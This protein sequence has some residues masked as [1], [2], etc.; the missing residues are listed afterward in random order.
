MSTL[1]NYTESDMEV[2]E[3]LQDYNV[4]LIEDFADVAS[5]DVL[6]CVRPAIAVPGAPNLWRP[7]SKNIKIDL[8]EPARLPN[9]T[10][11]VVEGWPLSP[12]IR[13][14]RLQKPSYNLRNVDIVIDNQKL[15]NLFSFIH[16][17]SSP[18]GLGHIFINALV[19]MEGNTAIWSRI[20]KTAPTKHATATAKPK[21]LNLGLQYERHATVSLMSSTLPKS[22]IHSRIISY[23]LAGLKLLLLY[24]ADACYCEHGPYLDYSDTSGDSTDTYPSVQYPELRIV[25]TGR[26]VSANDI[27]EI[28]THS[29]G[30]NV[31]YETN[32]AQLF[33]T[34]TRK[35]VDAHHDK[36]GVFAPAFLKD[37]SHKVQEWGDMHR[38]YILR[39]VGFLRHVSVL[40]KAN[41]GTLNVRASGGVLCICKPSNDDAKKAV[42][43]PDLEGLWAGGEGGE[44]ASPK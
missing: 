26:R 35:L 30:Q 19:Q 13:A 23:N 38:L 29:C 25:K 36:H 6:D 40:A 24:Q 22:V 41:G 42:L 7:A 21:Q 9:Q 28:K 17:R 44:S 14:V 2:F 8:S 27:I 10:W 15:R 37:I 20:P 5:Y 1:A 11:Q 16:P 34:Q 33:F 32:G 43:P 4:T 31:R 39:L 18:R 12:L 3:E